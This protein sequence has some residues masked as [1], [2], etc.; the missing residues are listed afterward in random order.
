MRP[1]C[2]PKRLICDFLRLVGLLIL[3]GTALSSVTIA[4]STPDGANGGAP[5]ETSGQ[6][7]TGLV[8]SRQVFTPSDTN[9]PIDAFLFLS[10]SGSQVV[11]PGTTWEQLEKLKRL[12]GGTQTDSDRYVFQ[13]LKISGATDSGRA[14]M[15]VTIQL[16]IEPTEGR[17]AKIPLGMNNFHL[18]AP[19]NVSGVTEHAMVIAENGGGYQ[20]WVRTDTASK[21]KL[22]MKV[23]ARVE[24]APASS[25]NFKLPNV[26]S[27]IALKVDAQDVKGEVISNLEE[28]V[29]SKAIN[30]KKTLVSVESNGGDFLLRWTGRRNITQQRA[31]LEVESRVDI[32]WD[33]P[34]DQ[35][36]ASVRLTARNV[37]GAIE[38][39]QIRLPAGSVLLDVPR[40]GAGG[41][42]IEFVPVETNENE[43]F[44][45]DG[46]LV[47]V[48]LPAEERQQRIDLN[49]ELQLS[50]GE[51][52]AESPLIM[53]VPQVVDALRHRG[54]VSLRLGE[55][56]R[57]RWETRP[58]VR[59]EPVDETE[60]DSGGRTYRFRFDRGSFEL[61][62]WLSTNERRLTLAVQSEVIIRG[63]MASLQM[64]VTVGGSVANNTLR[65]DDASWDVLS[66]VDQETGQYV[67][68]FMVGEDRVIQWGAASR[69]EDLVFLLTAQRPL[70]QDIGDIEF[71][72]PNITTS[73]NEVVAGESTLD[74]I[75]SGRTLMTVD[76]SASEGLTRITSDGSNSATGGVLSRFQ[77]TRF[78]ER[79]N[80][81]GTLQDQPLR[82]TLT[83][84]A[85]IE[86]DG[87]Q[88]ASTVD[89]TL[90]S[91]IDLEGRLPIRI[92]RRKR[93]Q[94]LV[95]NSL[96]DSEAISGLLPR[97]FG[98][99]PAEEPDK[100]SLFD[101]DN[102]F[103]RATKS[104]LDQWDDS[105][106]AWVVTVDGVPATLRKFEDDRFE[107]VSERLASGTMSIRWRRWQEIASSLDGKE[108][109]EV[110][111]P[112]PHIPDVTMRG[113]FAIRLR[114]DGESQLVATE[115]T[116]LN[117]DANEFDPR[118]LELSKNQFSAVGDEGV[119]PGDRVVLME[120]LPREPVRLQVR[121]QTTD[122]Q[123]LAIQ[124]MVLRTAIGYRT[125]QEQVLA[126]IEHGSEFSV[127]MPLLAR[128]GGKEE[129]FGDSDPTTTTA[130]QSSSNRSR[131]RSLLSL[132][133]HREGSAQ[134]VRVDALLDGQRV[135]VEKREGWLVV[136]LPGDQKP[137]SME[138]NIWIPQDSSSSISTIQPLVQLPG[139]LGRVFWQVIAPLDSH[140]FWASPTVGRAMSWR[141]DQWRL[142][143]Q[144][145]LSDQELARRFGGASI[146]MPPGNRYLYVGTDIPAFEVAIASRTILWLIVASTV[147]LLTVLLTYL[148]ATRNPVTAVIAAL[149]FAGLILIAPDAAVLAGQFGLISLVLVI[150]M[151]TI[152]SLLVPGRHDRVFATSPKSSSE[153]SSTQ[154]ANGS[155]VEHPASSVPA[156]R[157]LSE[158]ESMHPPKFPESNPSG[159]SE[160]PPDNS[161][162]GAEI[163]S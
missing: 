44:Q 101:R 91:P 108:V 74:L 23:S 72:L 138:L 21:A 70:G 161:A 16:N 94:S 93:D 31:L 25:L 32:R 61:P 86:I 95:D 38:R 37:R 151:M 43:F 53:T 147:L 114:G 40:M 160:L 15:E 67:E 20:W 152:R 59:S 39:F 103:G 30:E 4:Q 115:S 68:T 87:S 119:E 85:T 129:T 107:L 36:I 14:E 148:P 146:S 100:E 116:G 41:Q 84:K 82:V 142:Y 46:D 117:G 69:Q 109:Q 130:R 19:V 60:Q 141:F 11:V 63:A 42:S 158:T 50:G 88:L 134:Q 29:T 102:V 45:A 110:V 17:F 47:E 133:R 65:I 2:I 64:Q 123:D 52:S 106:G 121:A 90:D 139:G 128:S 145:S 62:I 98:G 97:I 18:L 150:V 13:S 149:L 137:H 157:G 77:I 48:I 73:E 76:L 131:R 57:L 126:T 105:E 24:S 9:L 156:L 125:R 81:V 144:S 71:P 83:P 34:Q 3:F 8:P 54:E 79:V 1:I 136:D 75:G 66:V 99:E 56:Y 12:E 26:P 55:D 51:I 132:S 155:L 80:V 49:F 112:R 143:R 58:W 92:P 118:V 163:A 27:T 120:T 122:M 135:S 113:N 33:S 104:V 6:R 96:L 111:F 153:S 140:V 78:G 28:V 22:K 154:I 124:Q 35:P 89:W 7:R 5:S 162:S 159:T 10:E 127:F